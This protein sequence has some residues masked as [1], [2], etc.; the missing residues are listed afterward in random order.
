MYRLVITSLFAGLLVGSVRADEADARKIVNDAIKAV[1][2]SG[3]TTAVTWNGKGKFYGMGDGI[4]FTGTWSIQPP[5]KFRMEINN[6]ATFIVNGDKGWIVMGG[7]TKEMTKEEVAEQREDMHVQFVQTLHPLKDKAYTL[8]LVG[9]SKVG[10]KTA[11][12]VKVS[13]KGRR[14][15]TLYFDK[16]SHLVAK[17]EHTVK[18]GDK[19]VIQESVVTEWTKRGDVKMAS[20]LVIKRDGKLYVES[21]MSDYKI[22]EKHPDGTFDK[23]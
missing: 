13:R 11:I 14:D 15:V 9:E 23:P 17:V 8:A 20:K 2:G 7:E 4:D 5:D 12:G 3:K 10:D 18:D 16:E 21:E 19:E 22:L 1:G 6:F